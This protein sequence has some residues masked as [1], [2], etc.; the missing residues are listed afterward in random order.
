MGLATLIGYFAK[1]D[2]ARAALRQLASQDFRRAALLHKGTDGAVHTADPFQ[3]HRSFG[4]AMSASLSAGLGWIVSS[5]SRMPQ[6]LQAW[7]LPAPWALVA[8]FAGTGAVAAACWLRRSRYGVDPGVLR[9]HARRLVSGESV[10]ILQ[11]PVEALL[12]P[13]ALLR[14]CGDIPPALFVVHPNCERRSE[15]RGVETKLSPAQILEHAER[16]AREQLL[17]PEPVPSAELLKRL[18]RSRLWIRQVCADL[19]QASRLEQKATPA[20]DWILDNEYILE[21]NLR[22]VLL[23]LPGSFFR[24]LPTLASDPYRGLPCIYGLAKNLASHSELR[25]ER[26]NILA[27]IEAHQSVRTLTIGELWAIPQM[28]RIALIES[29]QSLTVTAL[30]DL[31]ERQLADF[32]ANRLI[33]ANRRDANQLFGMLAEL[34][35]AEQH[36]TPYFG[37]Q[38]VGLLY[39]EAA[40]LA[41]VQSWLER[42]LKSPLHDISAREQNRQTREQM[43]CSNAFTSLRQLALLDWREMFEKLSRVEQALRRDPSGVYGALDFATRDRCRRAVED[44]AHASGKSEPQVAERAVDLA[45]QARLENNA[46]E[47]LGHVGAWLVGAGRS[48]LI[49]MLD[50]REALRYRAL[51]WIY[52]HHGAVYALGIGGFC[53]LFVLLSAAIAL[54]R[55]LAAAPPVLH[56]VLLLLLVVPASQLAI[57]VVNYLVTRLLPPRPLPKMD[58][59]ASGIPDAFRTLVVVPMLLADEATVR[60]EVEKLEIR[61]LA[62]KEANLL[63]SLFTDY[64]DSATPARADDGRLLLSATGA[65]AQL[66]LRHGE[67]FFLFHRERTWSTS[68]QKYIGWERKR[69]KLE[70]LNGLIDGTRDEGAAQLVYLGDPDRLTDV[71]FIITLDSDTQL[72]HATARRMVETL[73]HPLNQPRFDQAGRISSGYTIIQPRVSP[74]LTSTGASTFSRLFS[75]AVGIDPYTQAVSDVYQDLSGEGSY[76]GKGIYDVRAFSRVLSGRFPEEWVLSHDL[77]EGAH[78][79]VGLASD[80]ELYDEFPQG[81]QSYSSRAHR[82]IRGDWQIAGWIFPH[83]PQAL[84]GRGANQL[85]FLNRWKILDNLRRSLLPAASLALLAA[86]WFTAPAAGAIASLLVGMQLLFHPLA[87]PFTMA[88]TRKGLKYFSPAKL[89]H[90]VMRAGTDAAFLP[91]QAAV[92]LDAIARVCYR[93]FV[94][95]RDLLEWTAQATHWSA[96][97]RQPLFVAGLA[98]GSLFSALLGAALGQFS[99]ASL[100]QAAPWLA[101]WFVSP[102]LGWL[103]N[104]RPVEGRQEKP[105][106]EGDQRFLREVARRTWR[107]FSAFVDAETSWLPP[108]NYQVAHQNRRA[109]RTSPTNIGLWMTSALGAHDSGYLTV[110]QLIERLTGTMASIGRLQLYRGHLLNWYDIRTLAPLEPRYVSGVDS[111]N[112]LGALLVMEQGLDELAHGEILDGK[113]FAGLLD[114]GTILK[115]MVGQERLGG[116]DCRLLDQLMSDWGAPPER[117]VDKLRLLRRMKENFRVPLVPGGAASWAGEMEEQVAAWIAI[118]DRYLAW[119]EILAEKSEA[120]LA[121]L[122]PAALAA[123]RRDSS[124]APSLSD[125]AQGSVASIPLLRAIRERS[126]QACSPLESWMERVIAAFETAQWLAGETLGRLEQLLGQ[127]RELSAGMD[128]RFL[129]DPKQKLFA[130]GYNVSSDR[131]DASNYDLLASEARLGSFVAVARGDVPLEHWFSMGRPYGA[132]GRQRV[133]L[134]W[135]GT[136]FEYLMPLLFQR[137]YP[138]SL[139]DKAAREAVAV[140]IAYGRKLNLP[141][142]ISES[143]FADLDLEKTYQ[144]K[145]FGVPALGLK[146]SV[147][148]KLVVAPYATMLAVNLAP[149]QTVQNLKRLSELGLLGDYGYFE[150]I[151]FSRQPQRQGKRGVIVEAYMAHHQGMAFLSLTNFLHDNP[152]PRRFHGDARVRAYEALLQ[153]RIPTLPPLQLISTRTCGSE[154]AVEELV[155][156]ASSSFTT[157]H[158]QTP[159]SLLLSNGR[160]GLMVTNSGAGY[161]QWGRQELTRWRSDPTC[162]LGG[163]FLY[164]H[165]GGG[166]RLWSSTYHPV[167]GKVDEYLVDFTLD[168]AVFRRTDNGIQTETEVI[169]SPE[170]DVE[171]R[172]IT[173]VNRSSQVRHLNLTSYAELSLAPHNADRQHPAFNK[174]FIETEALFEQQALLAHRRP[175][176]AHDA[177]LYVAHSL[178][179]EQTEG[180]GEERPWQFETDRGRFIGRG[181]TLANP[182]GA[183]QDLGNSQGFVL[184]PMLGM[185]RSFTLEPGGR[186]RVSL[187]LAAGATRED[188]LL[189]LEKYS[190]PHA[191]ERALDFAWRSA[192]QQL[193]LLRIQPDEARR[194]QQLASH[195][196]FPNRL[197]RAP[198]ER[199]AENRLGQAGLWPYAISGDLP[200]V[201]VTVG[202]PR[203]ISLVRQMLQA[204]TYWRMHGFSTD[205]VILNEEGGSYERPLQERL[206][207]LIRT[208]ALSAASDRAGGIFLR[209][210]AQIPGEDLK[211]LKAA[212]GIVLVA[213]RGTLPQQLGAPVEAPEPMQA[214]PPKRAPR[215]P[216]APLPFME[217]NYFNSLGGFTQDG[218]EYA[219]YLG[220]GTNTPAPWVNVIANPNFGTLVSETGSG[221]TWYGNSQRNRLTGWSNDPVLDPATEALYIRDEESGAYWSP[222]A[223]PVR[224]DTAYRARHGAGYSVFEHNSNGIEQEL[225]VFVPVDEEGGEPVKLQR[226]RLTNASPRRRRL[227]VT[228]YVE[229]T[230]GESRESSQMHVVTE[231]D[232]DARALL[233]RNRYHP[234]Y[235][236]R[237]AFAAM[238]PGPD[239]Y[240]GDR[241][242][243]IGRNRTLDRPAAMELTRLSRRT[244]AGLDPCAVQ[245]VTLELAPGERRDI[246]CM[247]GQEASALKSRELVLRYREDRAFEDAF[248][249]TRAWWDELLGTVQVRTPELAADLLINRW[250]QYQSLSCRIWG[251]SG[252]YQSGGAFGFRDQLQ[253]V[254]AFLYARPEL[255]AKQILLA[256][257]RQFREGDV[258]HWWHEPA[259]AGIRSRISDDLLWLPYVVSHYVRTTGDRAI[260]EEEVPFLNAPPL[261]DD[262]H[263]VFSTPEVT[264]ERATLFE[265]C[266]RAVSRGLTVGPHGLP[267]MGTGDWNDG[268][269]LVGAAGKGESVWLAWFLCDILQGMEELSTLLLQTELSQ[270]YQKERYALVQRTEQAGWDGE[271]YLRGTFDDGSPLGSSANSEARIDSLPQSWA[272][273]C[274]AA[275]PLRTDRAM[276]AAWQHL[277]REDDGMVLLFEPPFDTAEPS[278]G[279]IKGYPPG[280]RENGGQY[281]HAALWMAMALARRGD[282]NRAAQIL[283]MLNPIEHA[284]DA[285]AAWLYGVEPYVVAADVYRLPGRIGQGGWSWYTGSAAWMYRAWVEEVLGLQV[286]GGQLRVNPVIPAAWQG[287]SMRYRHGETVYAIR[288]E[289]PQGC[290]QGVAWV[291]MDGQRVNGGVIDLERGLVQHQ[292]VVRMGHP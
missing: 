239:G 288:V 66:N 3:R 230:L 71:R 16:H 120:E 47:R 184:D 170:D 84:G 233:A 62:N 197:L 139:L 28:L 171:V 275:D 25:L 117:V 135:T 210:A 220:P 209:C 146:R 86:S 165:E 88:T 142:G 232:Q 252:F 291:E 274:G 218:R 136:M 187:V 144:Y 162:D 90:D 227:S 193:Q 106:P 9:D 1:K 154:L 191:T 244:G 236:E 50:G 4:I 267:L 33:A 216:S 167:G 279:Y 266:R 74:T 85:S 31:R 166:N 79:R 200:I 265:H 95:R 108:D 65:L 91:H 212:A 55:G 221:F 137:S 168:R 224:E 2:D 248:D 240:G 76:H 60:A 204:H 87:Q 164:I 225:T 207:Q 285:Q 41:P 101:L 5:L 246:V 118:S 110:S 152:F 32:W 37:A 150:A 109:M 271:W 128:M 194:F 231:W 175:R 159:R 151:D 102:L 113:A 268:M 148:E 26:D 161:S 173:L 70:E 203:E 251:R 247:L 46:D 143:A 124:R 269:N 133:L 63:F 147:E 235:G 250:L 177:P 58:F 243:F 94:S 11:A 262:Q 8:G 64:T 122:G 93:R 189:L 14:E 21:G 163:T 260:L 183:V 80:I 53:A 17:D 281:T 259:G 277:V 59:E 140:Q 174:L 40:A 69:G 20:A 61:Y 190:D 48:R 75:D 237:V 284:R 45:T 7:D 23:N 132:I 195:L 56:L 263:E 223:A 89:W 114:T 289:N 205:L 131:L 119:I 264:F 127:I 22:D 160:Y 217:L 241:A 242:A 10:L 228:Y 38:L 179:L 83:V 123:V 77:I 238:T 12:R 43:S 270:G 39:D 6:A 49:R 15:S 121:P 215:D 292:V 97:R 54:P 253:D 68:E 42:T 134:S 276:A 111:G 245:R 115:Q 283:R 198:A 185:R 29:I 36:P 172:R 72:P 273:L 234:E 51:E 96:S 141:W 130:I 257:S 286:Q 73:A 100:P 211:L 103:L 129:Y 34:A 255:A 186:A 156:P 213:A 116:F 52:C 206:E 158:T 30:A 149:E 98:L 27:F 92:A 81:Y 272:A 256:A 208:H 199:L 18:R 214:L 280:V 180:E 249:K 24:Q 254:M 104:L 202:E 82:W 222:T 155:A 112:L 105:L 282:G 57:E 138:G 35:G 201:L 157:P 181:R 125:L 290:Q 176:S 219:I 178:I 126:P 229:L 261:S 78:V 287:F 192:Q 226:L 19:S 278:P 182:M 13:V 67:R 99:P 153:E 145:A 258:Q 44:L 107:Y 196:L 188:V 169:V